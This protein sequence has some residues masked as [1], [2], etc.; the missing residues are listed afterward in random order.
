MRAQ[1]RARPAEEVGRGAVARVG[2]GRRV[3][4]EPGVGRAGR[5]REARR[6]LREG[7]RAEGRRELQAVVEEAH[8]VPGEDCV[9]ALAH[10][11]RRVAGR[12]HVAEAVEVGLALELVADG[13]EVVA[14][15]AEVGARA[16]GVNRAVVVVAR[17]ALRLEEEGGRVAG[18]GRALAE[19][20]ARGEAVVGD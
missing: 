9:A 12:R 4:A 5:G 18:H 19:R 6:A 16:Q 15:E 10:L 3:E 13:R 1:L 14:A 20:V 7:L 8:L 11:G 2:V 17:R